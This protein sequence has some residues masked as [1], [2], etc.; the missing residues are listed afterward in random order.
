MRSVTTL[1]PLCSN[2]DATNTGAVSPMINARKLIVR[3][4]SE[5]TTHKNLENYFSNYGAIDYVSITTAETCVVFK[6]AESVN[7]VLNTQPH[8]IKGTEVSLSKPDE[9]KASSLK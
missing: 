4:L 2:S 1:L 3:D 9:E 7:I 8:F 5:G 6:D